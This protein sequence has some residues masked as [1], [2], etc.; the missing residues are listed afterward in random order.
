MFFWASTIVFQK[1]FF[2]LIKLIV[3]N[4]S[5]TQKIGR[6]KRNEQTAWIK[7]AAHKIVMSSEFFGSELLL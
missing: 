6:Q 4:N 1:H 3:K 7:I 5:S 2:L